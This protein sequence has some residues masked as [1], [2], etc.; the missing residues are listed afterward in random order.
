[1]EVRDIFASRQTAVVMDR[2]GDNGVMM[3]TMLMVMANIVAR[4]RRAAGVDMHDRVMERH[5]NLFTPP[6]GFVEGASG[7]DY[8]QRGGYRGHRGGRGGRNR[9][10]QPPPPVV[11]EP[12]ASSEVAA[13]GQTPELS[14]QVMDA[15]MV[16]VNAE[17]PE[18]EP[19]VMGTVGA[20]D[21]SEGDKASKWARKKEKMLC[22]RC[23]ERGTL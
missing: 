8:R 23:G 13:S 16:L 4:R 5:N 21:K 22:Y 15:V 11:V 2:L 17:V 10:R 9:Y 1:M 18:T 7:P 6:G 19:M 12:T 20:A 3:V 14:G